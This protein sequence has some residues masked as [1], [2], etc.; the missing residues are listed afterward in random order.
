MRPLDESLEH[1]PS[2]L[3]FAR[4]ETPINPDLSMLKEHAVCND[5]PL[6]RGRASMWTLLPVLHG[7]GSHLTSLLFQRCH[8][9]P[10]DAVKFTSSNEFCVAGTENAQQ[11]DQ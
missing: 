5:V 1:I 10:V 4:D 8:S 3:R 2:H 6:S 9:L 11:T 7:N